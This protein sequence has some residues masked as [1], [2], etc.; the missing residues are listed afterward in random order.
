[1][2]GL[3]KR[4]ER[5]LGSCGVYVDLVKALGT[6][7]RGALWEVL[8]KFAKPGHFMGMHVRLH[9]GAGLPLSGCGARYRKRLRAR[10][11]LPIERTSRP[12][13]ARLP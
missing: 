7:N 3:K 4:Q 11:S 9:A 6:V 2:M 13:R 12:H 8:G 10:L 1:M 5:G